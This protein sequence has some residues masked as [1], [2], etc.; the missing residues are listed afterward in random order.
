MSTQPNKEKVVYDLLLHE[1]IALTREQIMGRTGLNAHQVGGILSW[2]A[3]RNLVKKASDFGSLPLWSVIPVEED[4]LSSELA[5]ED[6]KVFHQLVVERKLSFPPN[7]RVTFVYENGREQEVMTFHSFIFRVTNDG[8][9]S[10]VP[11]VT[12]IK[13][14]RLDEHD[15]VVS[16][17]FELIKPG[18]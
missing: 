18:E 15:Q 8:A 2:L 16:E 12:K 6:T 9:V 1:G 3:K 14:E 11:G 13:F 7:T 17:E 10:N 4:A 5:K